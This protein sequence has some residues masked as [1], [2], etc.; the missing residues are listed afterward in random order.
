LGLAIFCSLLVI[1]GML[2][3]VYECP[4]TT[5]EG[6]NNL[7]Y[8]WWG[9]VTGE[10]MAIAISYWKGGYWAL[11]TIGANLFFYIGIFRHALWLIDAWNSWDATHPVWRHYPPTTLG[12]GWWFLFAGPII[13]AVATIRDFW[14]VWFPNRRK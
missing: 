8:E 3:P 7:T 14:P 11:W 13:L 10:L 12:W 9:I 5:F 2:A 6:G 1:I 4:N